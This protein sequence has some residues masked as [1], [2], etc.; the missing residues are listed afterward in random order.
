MLKGPYYGPLK[1]LD[2]SKGGDSPY[3]LANL[4]KY[5]LSRLLE[6][7][8]ETDLQTERIVVDST[9]T[10]GGIFAGEFQISD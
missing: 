7:V 1:H 8:L 9:D 3:N 10:A 4:T 6:F 2:R 5:H